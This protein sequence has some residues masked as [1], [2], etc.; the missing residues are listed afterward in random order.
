MKKKILILSN[1]D[2]TL[3][4]TRM[5]LIESLIKQG[6]EVSVSFPKTE[7]VTEFEKLGC[8]YI[9]TTTTIRRRKIT[10][11]KDLQL[12]R[13]YK[14]LLKKIRPDIVFAYTVKPNVYGGIAAKKLKIP[15]IA[16]ITGLGI[17]ERKGIIKRIGILLHRYALNKAACVFCQNEDNEK[18]LNNHQIGKNVL[19]KIP[20]SG[21][22]L[23]KFKLIPYPKEDTIEFLFIGRILKQKGIEEYIQMA[24]RIKQKYP[25]IRFHVLG[26][27]EEE[28]YQTVLEE[29]EKKN[30]LIY[31]GLQYDIRPFLE[32]CHI[33]VHPTYHPEGMSNVLLEALASGRPII[34][35]NR[36]GCREIVEDKVNGYIVKP[37][38]VQDLTKKVEQFLLLSNQEK[39]TM[40]EKGRK[41][42]EKEFDRKIVVRAYLEEIEKI[43]KRGR[44]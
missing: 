40:G 39:K 44:I 22:N 9:E 27:C 15:Y 18:F 19:R 29:A 31:H 32:M 24:E 36:S 3:L 13:E 26:D 28:R 25:D 10:P 43:E 14:N 1:R 4:F 16:N 41:K 20:G 2:I 30:I 42:V 23:E 37:K 17:L 11:L 5:E 6:Y 34:T 38:D 35:T 33:V 7:K 8:Q 12:I 21:V